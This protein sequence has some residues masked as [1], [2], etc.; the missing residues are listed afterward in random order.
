MPVAGQTTRIKFWLVRQGKPI[1][2]QV[3]RLR[4]MNESTGEFLQANGLSFDET[5]SDVYMMEPSSVGMPG[6]YYYDFAQGVADAGAV[7]SY[8][9]RFQ[10]NS[11]ESDL[12]ETTFSDLEYTSSLLGDTLQNEDGDQMIMRTRIDRSNR[13]FRPLFMGAYGMTRV[14]RTKRVIAGKSQT[15]NPNTGSQGASGG[16]GFPGVS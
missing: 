1:P 11:E 13:G 7:A 9:L 14:R 8:I 15:T 4:I 2:R 12:F 3:V 6:Y 5:V 10:V 16:S